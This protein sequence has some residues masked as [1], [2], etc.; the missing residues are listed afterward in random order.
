MKQVLIRRI[1]Q[2]M[3]IGILLIGISRTA[4]GSNEVKIRAIQELGY[5]VHGNSRYVCYKDL[6][7]LDLDYGNNVVYQK[8]DGVYQVTDRT[9]HEILQT[10]EDPEAY[11]QHE[12]LIVALSEEKTSFLIYDMDSGE[13]YSYPCEKG[14]QID[15][16][17]LYQG[18]IYYME[19]MMNDDGTYV[20]DKT[21]KGINL[22]KGDKRIIYQ[23]EKPKMDYFWFFIREDGMIFCEWGEKGNS[24]REYWKIQ[25]DKEGKWVETKLWETD[26]WEYREW[27]AFNKWGLIVI[28]EL[29]EP[30]QLSFCEAIVIKDNGETE[31]VVIEAEKGIKLFLENGY[32][33]NDLSNGATGVTFY[34]YHGNVI[35]TYQLIDG[36]YIEKGYHLARLFYY[37]DRITGLYVQKGTNELYIAQ[38][39][40]DSMIFSAGGKDM[41][42]E[43]YRWDIIREDG[44]IR[45]TKT[46]N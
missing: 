34:D 1:S 36:E 20:T 3:L 13:T 46:E 4:Y 6:L 9:L 10:E 12:N 15:C 40:A 16:W 11:M 5:D 26:Q 8:Q 22:D 31:E 39:R 14:K 17:Y 7:I 44:D 25:C 29:Y 43:Y 23:S 42:E 27:M 45:I 30:K 32:L 41:Y 28:G 38:V 35:E 19:R 18:E 24:R 21:I 37:D 33:V 2:I